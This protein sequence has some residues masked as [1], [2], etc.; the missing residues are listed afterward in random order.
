M[1][2]NHKRRGFMRSIFS[3]AAKPSAPVQYSSKMINPSP[4]TQPGH[5]GFYKEESSTKNPSLM[6]KSTF[7][8][9]KHV[10]GFHG[11]STTGVFDWH[12]DYG[13]DENVD[14]KAANYISNVRERF[15]LVNADLDH[16][17]R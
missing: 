12:S 4:P 3:L 5:V 9:A 14:T 10:P 6:P 15:K 2:R 11:S 17:T 8:A 7:S 1:E 13:G 16:R